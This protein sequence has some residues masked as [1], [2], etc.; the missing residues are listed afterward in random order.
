MKKSKLLFATWIA[1]CLSV[2]LSAQV[3]KNPA[4]GGNKR[5][6]VSEEIGITQV[7]VWYNRPGVKGRE[8]HIYGTNVVYKGYQDMSVLF[9]TAKDAPWRAGANENTI[10][11]FSTDVKVEGKSLPAG[12]YGLF[13]AYDP[14][15]CTVI[16]SKNTSSWGNFFYTE[17]EDALR[18][19]VK[20]VA[21]DKSVEWLKY[22]FLN[23]TPESAIVALEWEKLEIPFL[24]EVD[25]VKTELADFRNELRGDKAFTAD[26]YLQAATFCLD[27][28]VNYPEALTWAEA[29]VNTQKTFQTLNTKGLLLEKLGKTATADSAMK[30]AIPLA[31]MLDLHQYAKH[32]LGLK[33]NAEA[34]TV[35]KLNAKKH[36]NQFIT[37]AGLTR[38]YSANGDDKTALLNAKAALPLAPN[39]PNK[40]AVTEMIKKLE[41]GKDVN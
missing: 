33:R 22:E 34:L 41:S 19:K 16:F 12:K 5:A 23:Q 17:S 37:Y 38:G 14:A 11:E 27:H 9:G 7:S 30:E 26:G 39:E 20:P 31:T 8:G 13:V 40:A 24:V 3:L 4:P 6:S 21:L 32:L 28:E 2:S 36:P 29:A 35:F 15:E 10:I 25:L 18:V 1:L